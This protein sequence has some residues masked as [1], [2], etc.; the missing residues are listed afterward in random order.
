MLHLQACV[1]L[2]EVKVALLVGNKLYRPGTH[3]PDRPR[4]ITRGL[5]HC[6][7]TRRQHPRC[8]CLLEHF[9]MPALHGAI[10]LKQ[11]DNIP[12]CIGED[13]DL[14]MPRLQDVALQQDTVISKSSGGLALTSR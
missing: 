6:S 3:V 12:V 10:T 9:L 13:L 7:T 5:A 8:G 4:S 2:H 14:D 11:A 1:H